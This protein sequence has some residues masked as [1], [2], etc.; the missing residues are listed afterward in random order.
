MSTEPKGQNLSSHIVTINVCIPFVRFSLQWPVE[1]SMV[2]RH[3]KPIGSTLLNPLSPTNACSE[4]PLVG[5]SGRCYFGIWTPNTRP[6]LRL[7]PF[8]TSF[9]LIIASVYNYFPLC[10]LLGMIQVS[11]SL[12][13]RALLANYSVR[14]APYRERRSIVGV[15]RG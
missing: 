13:R 15:H 6:R 8:S 5:Y 3:A 10:V 12:H 1:A 11:S 4:Q 7:Y 9:A 14:S 2:V